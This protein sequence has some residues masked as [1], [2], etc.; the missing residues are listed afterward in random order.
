[1]LS[2]SSLTPPGLESIVVQSRS[3]LCPPFPGKAIKLFFLTHPKLLS[4][5]FDSAPLHRGQ[6]FSSERT[7]CFL[8]RK[9]AWHATGIKRRPALDE[10]ENGIK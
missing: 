8:I 3:L 4:P 9:G 6:G 1:L 10:A 5:R 2:N 7:A